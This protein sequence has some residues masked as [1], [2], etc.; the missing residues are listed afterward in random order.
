MIKESDEELML[1]YASDDDAAAFE[2]LY[3]RY[4]AR[5]FSYLVKN[6]WDSKDAEEIHQGV[7]LKMHQRKETYD[8][9][10]PFSAWL[11]TMVKTTMI[12]DFRKTRTRSNILKHTERIEVPDDEDNDSV[13]DLSL[14]DQLDDSQKKLLELRYLEEWS[15]EEMA[16][17]FK[18]NAATIR[19]R[20]SRLLK[21]LRGAT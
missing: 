3:R 9:K 2:E 16:K 10:F 8:S 18:V 15:F 21:Q 20:I 4:S 14:T 5:V 1:R 19:K 12:D 7:F 11:F 13:P 6:C 17:E